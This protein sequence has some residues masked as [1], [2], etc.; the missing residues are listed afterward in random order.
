MRST[1][2]PERSA[3]CPAPRRGRRRE[4]RPSRQAGSACKR[5]GAD[6]EFPSALA[7][8]SRGPADW[9]RPGPFGCMRLI[10]SWSRTTAPCSRSS[11]AFRAGRSTGRGRITLMF[12][13]YPNRALARFGRVQRPRCSRSHRPQGLLKKGASPLLSLGWA[14]FRIPSLNKFSHFRRAD[15]AQRSYERRSRGRR[16]LSQQTPHPSE[17]RGLRETLGGSC[18]PPWVR[19]LVAP[20]SGQKSVRRFVADAA[21]VL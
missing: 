4:P 12:A 11:R 18:R 21:W 16:R 10:G 5:R 8:G 17:T 3:G 13:H 20:V 7:R 19:P 1:G 9:H 14:I 2:P 15:L 6:R